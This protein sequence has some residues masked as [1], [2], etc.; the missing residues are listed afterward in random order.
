MTL[1]LVT[2]ARA[3]SLVT[4][5]FSFMYTDTASYRFCMYT[6][7]ASYRFCK[8]GFSLHMLGRLYLQSSRQCKAYSCIL[9]LNN[10]LSLQLFG[11]MCTCC[12]QNEAL[13]V[14]CDPLDVCFCDLQQGAPVE[15]GTF[16]AAELHQG[17]QSATTLCNSQHQAV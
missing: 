9:M 6:Y 5:S 17:C 11:P 12:S 15:L 1:V 10:D 8:W 2:E 3:D 7:T 4:T 13:S 16:D 14:V